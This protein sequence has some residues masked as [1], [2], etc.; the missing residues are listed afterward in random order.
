MHHRWTLGAV[1]HDQLEQVACPISSEYQVARRIL[2]N[3][4]H[5]Q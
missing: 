1:E 5:E 2:G 4:L 3:L